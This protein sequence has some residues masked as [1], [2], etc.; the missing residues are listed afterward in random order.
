M[1]D[2]ALVTEYVENLTRPD[3]DASSTPSGSHDKVLWR[4]AHGHQWVT[5]ARQRIK[6]GSQCPVCL[7]GLWTSRLEFQVAE[8]ISAASG[9]S[10]IVG[11]R[12]PRANRAMD[13]RVDLL[14]EDIDLLVD[15]D[16]A[17]WHSAPEA[18]ERDARKLNRLSGRRYVRIRSLAIGRLVGTPA[19]H[20]QQVVLTGQDEGDPALWAA[21]VLRLL[22]LSPTGS[23]DVLSGAARSAALA[24]ADRRWRNLR[25]EPRRRSL[26]S[27]HP[28]VA[29]EFVAA[30]GLPGVTAVELAPGG[31]DRVLWQCRDCGNQWEAQVKNRTQLGTGCPPCSYARGASRVSSPRP[32]ESF[33]EVH[34]DLLP[35]FVEDVTRP[36]RSLGDLKPNSV[37]SC[38]WTCPHC[39]GP[40]TATPHDL[41]RH[42]SRGCRACGYR[43]GAAK[44]RNGR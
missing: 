8:L 40:W 41:H 33:A 17:R 11:A 37:D 22:D 19:T 24:R 13:D 42:P 18:L 31:D 23:M 15:L 2:P 14:I 16:P 1:A 43:R 21:A 9:Y 38:R 3:R 25:A 39:G 20:A 6:Y 32:G 12:L 5:E 4:C 27:E 26:A 35:Y 44:R 29:R 36:G 10:V 28:D 7:A 34:P 30:V